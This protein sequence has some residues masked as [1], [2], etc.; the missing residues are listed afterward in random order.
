MSNMFLESQVFQ[1][2]NNCIR[3]I[4]INGIFFF[5][6]C[7]A[8]SQTYCGEFSEKDTFGSDYDLTFDKIFSQL[9]FAKKI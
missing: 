1:C 3:P 7:S 4:E 5:K 8:P 6:K 9:E 2:Y